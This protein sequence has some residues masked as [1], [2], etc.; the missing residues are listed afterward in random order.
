MKVDEDMKK[1]H[2]KIKKLEI[3]E[4]FF[5]FDEEA[6][7]RGKIRHPINVYGSRH[8]CL[9]QKKIASHSFRGST[10]FRSSESTA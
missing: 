5:S 3:T 1:R 6:S 7:H 9:S 4:F 8:N 10:V 2:A